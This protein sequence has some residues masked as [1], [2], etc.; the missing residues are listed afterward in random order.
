MATPG[1]RL[2]LDVPRPV[3]GM[4]IADFP[5]LLDEWHE[6]LNGALDPALIPAGGGE[7]I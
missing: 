6:T 2:T 5:D 3:A 4:V 7:K 1:P